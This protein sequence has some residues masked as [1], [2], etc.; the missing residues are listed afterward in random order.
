VQCTDDPRHTMA[1]MRFREK[2]SEVD[3]VRISDDLVV[4]MAP[5]G[6]L[7]GIERLEAND[8]LRR[9]AVL[10]QRRSSSSTTRPVNT[11]NCHG[12]LAQRC[13]RAQG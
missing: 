11:S 2:L 8:Q 6:T 1:Y 7:S 3:S 5:D 12:R 10:R 13:S 9:Y 4:E